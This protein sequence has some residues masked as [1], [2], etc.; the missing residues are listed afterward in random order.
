MLIKVIENKNAEKK[1]SLHFL[2]LKIVVFGLWKI[3]ETYK[4]IKYY[5]LRLR[6]TTGASESKNNPPSPALHPP[7]EPLLSECS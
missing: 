2:F 1:S 6:N 7:P 3:I 4:L 5:F